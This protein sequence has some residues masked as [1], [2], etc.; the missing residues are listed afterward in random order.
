MK[1]T[2]AILL[3]LVF[4]FTAL[5]EEAADFTFSFRN[6]IAWGMSVEEVLAAEGNPKCEVED[7]DDA[8]SIEIEDVEYGDAKCDLDYEFLDNELF[9]ITLDFDTE[10]ETI[11]FDDLKA[12]LVEVYGEPGEFSDEVKAELEEEDLEDLDSIS[13]WTLADGTNIWLMEDTDEHDIE[14]VFTDIS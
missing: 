4:C 5:A 2:L 12:K 10:E 8:Q 7:E 6:G 13:S 3:L 11:T 1:K 14:I 9:M